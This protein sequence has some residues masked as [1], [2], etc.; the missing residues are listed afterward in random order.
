[1]K[2]ALVFSGLLILLLVGYMGE[3]LA[4]SKTDACVDQTTGDIR[5]LLSGGSC[6]ATENAIGLS[7]TG[8]MGP[9]GPKG[10]AGPKGD[11]GPQGP[12]GPPGPKGPKGP[13]GDK[14][15][16]EQGPQGIQGPQGPKGDTGA[17]GP[18]G[19]NGLT[20][21][22][23]PKGDKGDTGDT[24]PQGPP[25]SSGTGAGL[26]VYAANNQFVGYLMSY[27][28]NGSAS[29]GT[30]Y[31]PTLNKVALLRPATDLQS[32]DIVPVGI[33][34]ADDLCSSGILLLGY[35]SNTLVAD[36]NG[37]YYT[38]GTLLTNSYYPY[39]SYYTAVDGCNLCGGVDCWINSESVNPTGVYQ[40]VQVP[41]SSIPFDLPIPGPLQFKT[42]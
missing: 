12:V 1:V 26:K 30:V 3:A 40:G 38:G 16:G 9:T 35:D 32:F 39:G 37:H 8:K 29:W 22:P 14:G 11:K 34:Y 17:A 7:I 19:T 33:Y 36:G 2:K 10:A 5:L 42:Q 21:P 13:K 25:G 27:T 41:T 18:P 15:A 23:G 20:G 31:I 28:P 4:A 24:G 6:N